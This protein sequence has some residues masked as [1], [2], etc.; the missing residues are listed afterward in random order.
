MA[1]KDPK[2]ARRTGGLFY[3]A[4]YTDFVIPDGAPAKIRDRRATVIV[5]RMVRIKSSGFSLAGP[6]L[7]LSLGR[8]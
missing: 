7:A 8:G 6:E 5:V 1:E 3:F 4:T 2:K